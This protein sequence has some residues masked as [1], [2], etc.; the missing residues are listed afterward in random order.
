MA[1]HYAY[2]NYQYIDSKERL[3]QPT[4]GVIEKCFALGQSHKLKWRSET[5]VYNTAKE[6]R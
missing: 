4:V 1:H 6:Q 2:Q 5:G 3:H